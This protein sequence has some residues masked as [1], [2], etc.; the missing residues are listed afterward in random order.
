[1]S[2]TPSTRKPYVDLSNSTT[3]AVREAAV[4]AKEAKT[5]SDSAAAEVGKLQR[6]RPYWVKTLTFKVPLEFE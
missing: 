4:G 2:E 1:V 3:S 5:L 6:L